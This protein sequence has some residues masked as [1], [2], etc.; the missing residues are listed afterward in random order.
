MSKLRLIV[1]ALIFAGAVIGIVAYGHPI[2]WLGLALGLIGL[3]MLFRHGP[4]YE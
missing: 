2:R 4:Y 3:V 1:S